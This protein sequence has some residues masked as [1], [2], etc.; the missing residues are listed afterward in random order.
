MR[1]KNKKEKLPKQAIVINL[2]FISD[3]W[4]VLKIFVFVFFF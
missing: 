4:I 1:N 3:E 2:W